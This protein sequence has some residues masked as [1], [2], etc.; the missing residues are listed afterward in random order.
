MIT[1]MAQHEELAP[2][3][4]PGLPG[5]STS[6]LELL[7]EQVSVAHDCL[8]DAAADA[9]AGDSDDDAGAA[10]QTGAAPARRRG[11]ARRTPNRRANARSDDAKQGCVL[12]ERRV[13][14]WGCPL[15]DRG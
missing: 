1:A 3:L 6:V 11:R 4:L 12:R 8:A 14:V 7:Q 13:G 10:R 2:L 9:A 5:A 15:H